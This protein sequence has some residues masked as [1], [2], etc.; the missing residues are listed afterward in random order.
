MKLKNFSV[1]VDVAGKTIHFPNVEFK[2]TKYVSGELVLETKMDEDLSFEIKKKD[3]SSFLLESIQ[4]LFALPLI[5][6][7]K[8]IIPDSGRFFMGKTYPRQVW[9]NVFSSSGRA[10]SNPFFILNNAFD[11]VD[12][13]FGLLGNIYE[14][15]IHF[16]SP[17]ANKKNSMTVH[18]GIAAGK[19]KWTVTKPIGEELTIGKIR[20]F[21]DGIFQSDNDKSWFHALRK[22]GLAFQK[23]HKIKYFIQNEGFRPALCTWRVINSDSMTDQ[24]ILKTAKLAKQAGM[25]ALIFDDGWYGVGLDGQ[26]LKSTMGDWPWHIPG[27]FK[28]IRE[29]CK[30]VKKIGIAPVLWYCPISISPDSKIKPKVS[31]LLAWEHGSLYTCPARFHTLCV[32]SPEARQVMIKNLLKLI[33]YGA[34]GIK[35]DLFDYMPDTPC[36]SPE[37]KHDCVTTTDGLRKIYKEL[38]TAA[39]KKNKKIIYSIKNNYGNVELAGFSSNVRGGDSPFDENIN[40]L[41]SIYPSAYVPVVHDDYLAFTNYEKT[42]KVAILLIKQITTG[43]PNFSLNLE[44]LGKAHQYILKKWLDFFNENLDLYRPGNLKTF[45]P[46]NSEMT[47]FERVISEKAMISLFPNSREFEFI[48]RDKVIILNTTK[49]GYAYLTNLPKGV[50]MK[51]DFN[52]KIESIKK[53]V[54]YK[55]TDQKVVIPSAGLTVFKRIKS[56]I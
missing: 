40:T 20:S 29:T 55:F 33:D 49:Y 56:K 39:I 36:N 25:K 18:G 23:E 21:K 26:S 14:T 52:Y 1:D 13:S 12:F 19:L 37:H 31:H 32:R 47:V 45:Q 27:K 50:W 24:W 41:R 38:Y 8:V 2:T 15:N 35:V 11:E 30:K 5:N 16:I 44:K 22:Y 46:Q 28:D 53:I 17:G 54:D 34:E 10:M 4:Y 51:E 3:G 6:F 9:S 42:D 7:G 43:V 48:D